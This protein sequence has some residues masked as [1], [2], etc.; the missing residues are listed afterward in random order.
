[1]SIRRGGA[2]LLAT[3]AC[4]LGSLV[5][6]ATPASAST[7]GSVSF[8]QAQQQFMCT[9]C[10]EPLNEA[11][12]PE[13]FQEN[14][15]LRQL[16][17]HGNS[18]REIKH[19]MVVQYGVAVLAVPPAH[20]FSLLVFVIPGVVIVLGLLVIA[21][22]IPRWRRRARREAAEPRAPEPPMSDADAERLDAD[23]ARQG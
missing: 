14:G 1:M 15:Y 22:T 18:L 5:G 16:I 6:T 2:A 12:S 9:I 23:L 4:A 11:R 8:T 3:L 17:A 10:H 7:H 21:Y 13:A 20:G 19:D